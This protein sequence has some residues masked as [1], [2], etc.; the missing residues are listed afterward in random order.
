M[1]IRPPPN[2]RVW[3]RHCSNSPFRIAAILS[4]FITAQFNMLTYLTNVQNADRIPGACHNFRLQIAKLAPHMKLLQ[5]LLVFVASFIY[6]K[7][8]NP[9]RRKGFI[10]RVAALTRSFNNGR[11]VDGPAMT[12]PLLPAM[13]KRL[14]GVT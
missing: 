11:L 10:G 7:W 9:V 14:F 6:L 5:P 4:K 8:L 3:L 13:R 2:Y 12:G 1:N